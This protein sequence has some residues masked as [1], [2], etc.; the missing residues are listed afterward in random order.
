MALSDDD[1]LSI[2]RGEREAA[3]GD[4]DEL[5][6]ERARNYDYFYADTEN[7]AYARDLPVLAGQS[8][9]VSTDVADAVETVLPDLMEIF[10]GGDNVVSFAPVSKEDEPQAEQ[11]TDYVNHVFFNENDGWMTLYTHIKDALISKTGIFKWWW[12][13]TEEWDELLF[14]DKTPDEVAILAAQ[15]EGDEIE[16]VDDDEITPD[17]ATGLA[18]FRVRRK[19]VRG[20]ARIAA[21]A[22]E[23]FFI[24]RNATSPANATMAGHKAT[25]RA[26]ELIEQGFDADLVADLRDADISDDEDALS[27][28]SLPDENEASPAEANELMRRVEI[29]EY[30]I[31][32]NVEDD[33][34]QCWKIITGNDD[35]V[36]LDKEKIAGIQFAANCPYPTT[37]KFY[38]RSLADLL[39]DVQKIKT[40]LTRLALNAAYYGVNPR[41]TIDM[42]QATKV[43]ISDLLDNKPGKPIRTNGP[44]AI[45]WQQPPVLG[46]DIF[47]SL[48]YMAT[49]GENRTGIVR[50]AQ[51]LNPDTLHDTAKGAM[52]LMSASQR[53]VRMIARLFAETGIK[54][55]FVGLHD[56][57]VRHARKAETIRL[58][59]EWVEVDPNLWGRRKDLNVDVGLGSHTKSQEA[60]FWGGVIALQERAAQFGLADEKNFFNAAKKLLQAGNVRTPERYFVNPV[61]KA[62]EEAKAAALA[63]LQNGRQQETPA[64][65]PA[66]IKLQ[67]DIALARQKAASD[68]EI[69]RARLDIET[70]LAI[71]KTQLQAGLAEEAAKTKAELET[72]KVLSGADDKARQT[73]IK[74]ASA[75][76]DVRFGGEIG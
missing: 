29:C 58:R 24:D 73:D 40:A 23:D 56:L 63:A 2:V 76:K 69:K 60:A 71:F 65:D 3:L 51:G 10:A 27:R 55:L 62:E 35:T 14:E 36:L 72:F 5:A 44:S 45:S 11:E 33:D 49:V 21:I 22:P 57:I 15:A 75:I 67:A 1:I 30:H 68:A 48:E 54:D 20:R 28:S 41:P 31:K 53:R 32:L 34:F 18:T 46:F 4:G 6:H 43:T 50:N 13:E 37:H 16:L 7:G 17:P 64:P 39:I 52:E 70:R 59:N 9:A 19:Q 26:Y 47:G 74:L 12:E 8:A 61:K 66:L 25:A 42:K 38:G